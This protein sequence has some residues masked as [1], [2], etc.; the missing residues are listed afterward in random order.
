MDEETQDQ[1]LARNL[2]ELLAEL[3]VAQA[4][5]QIL[6]GF[7]LS[8]VF[9][10]LFREASGFEKGMHLVAVVLTALATALLAAPAAWHRILFRAGRRTDILRVGNRIVLVGLV[11]LAAAVSDVVCLIAKV[12]YG[13][14]AMGVVGG[15]VA[16]AFVLL[17]FVVPKLLGR[18][19]WSR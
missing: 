7:L 19:H 5:V 12:V 1:R 8:V 10:G 16:I 11:C 4:G 6:F 13:P 3:R 15:L 18:G 2:N 17:W 9:T 14:V